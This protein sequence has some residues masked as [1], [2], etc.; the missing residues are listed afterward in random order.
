MQAA[1]SRSERSDQV[2]FDVAMPLIAGATADIAKVPSRPF[3]D[4]NGTLRLSGGMIPKHIATGILTLIERLLPGDGLCHCDLH[5]GNVIMTADGPRI[6][7][8]LAAARPGAALDLACCRV[9]NSSSSRSLRWIKNNNGCTHDACMFS[10]WALRQR[11]MKG[12][13]VGL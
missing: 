9:L 8:L 3:P 5:P 12:I 13:G 11:Y 6:I 4:I 10:R 2:R 7:D 1:Y